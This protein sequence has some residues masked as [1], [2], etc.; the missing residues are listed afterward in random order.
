MKK[1][2]VLSL[3]DSTLN[4]NLLQ[5]IKDRQ[6]TIA[7]D[8]EHKMQANFMESLRILAELENKNYEG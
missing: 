1:L 7:S 8:L 5:E 6:D 4:T 2:G 3:Q